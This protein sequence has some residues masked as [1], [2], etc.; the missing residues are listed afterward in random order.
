MAGNVLDNMVGSFPGI[1]PPK[2]RGGGSEVR[3]DYVQHALSALIGYERE[4]FCSRKLRTP[5]FQR[6]AEAIGWGL[7]RLAL[8]L[9]CFV[10]LIGTTLWARPKRSK[11]Q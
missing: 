1:Y 2:G 7:K 6:V 5:V 4:R 9:F 3:I 8:I 11:L 10:L